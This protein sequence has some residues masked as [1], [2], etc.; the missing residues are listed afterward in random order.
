MD[1]R[2]RAIGA[3]EYDPRRGDGG[4]TDSSLGS[5]DSIENIAVGSSKPSNS[6]G[7]SAE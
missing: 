3:F 5:I 7:Y 1:P 2:L 6:V 4:S